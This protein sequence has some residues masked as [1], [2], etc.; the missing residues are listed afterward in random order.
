VNPAIGR[1]AR[2]ISFTLL[3]VAIL[4]IG[5]WC[6]LA[7]LM[8]GPRRNWSGIHS[9]RNRSVC[10]TCSCHKQAG[11]PVSLSRPR[12]IVYSTEAPPCKLGADGR[13]RRSLAMGTRIMFGWGRCERRR[14]ALTT[15]GLVWLAVAGSAMGENT[16]DGVYTGNRVLTSGSTAVCMAADNVSVTISGHKFSFSDSLV[17]DF[18]IAFDASPDGSFAETYQDIGGGTVTIKGRVTGDIMEADVS[19][20]STACVHH[21]HLTRQHQGQ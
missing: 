13:V 2:W 15:Y 7:V 18:T 16:F 3:A 11:R 9:R 17:Q 10:M 1:L 6:S 4:L 14:V 8:M 19:D 5:G 20:D 12:A 21:W